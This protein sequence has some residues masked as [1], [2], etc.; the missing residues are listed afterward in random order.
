MSVKAIL[1][2][3]DQDISALAEKSYVDGQLNLKANKTDVTNSLATKADTS[4]VTTKLGQKA[5]KSAVDAKN[6]I[7][8]TDISAAQFAADAADTKASSAQTAANEA[9]TT[10][11][12]AQT[13]ANNALPKSGGTMTGIINM[14][15][16]KITNLADPTADTD[17]VNKQYVDKAAQNVLVYSDWGDENAV[18]DANWWSGLRTWVLSSSTTDNMLAACLG[19]RKK[20]SLSTAVQGGNAASMMCVGYN[21][22]GSGKSLTFQ[23]DILPTLGAFSSSSALW[24]GSNAQNICNNFASYCSANSSLK[25]VTILYCSSNSSG[26]GQNTDTSYQCYGFLP[27]ECQMGCTTTAGYA[28]SQS[29]WTS[30]GKQTPYQYYTSDSSRVKY[31]MDANGNLTSSANYYWERSRYYNNSSYVCN[32]YNNGYFNSNIYSS[33]VGF[34]PAFV[35]G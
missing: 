28:K 21:I 19:K 4:D 26:Q 3:Q 25:R 6:G 29:E 5:D 24:N 12:S 13:T 14:G 1:T 23:S 18:G 33:S 34:A 27:S 8:D 31:K 30:G 22:D 11:S 16:K 17:M 2:N 35:I 32:V 15:S 7:Q 20:V 10:A 9:K